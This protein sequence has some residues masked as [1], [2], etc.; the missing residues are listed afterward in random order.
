[1][2]PDLHVLIYFLNPSTPR[3]G[4]RMLFRANQRGQMGTCTQ[5][6]SVSSHFQSASRCSLPI[7]HIN[8]SRAL[9][10]AKLLIARE[11]IKWFLGTSIDAEQIFNRVKADK[12]QI[13]VQLL[14]QFANALPGTRRKCVSFNTIRI[15][16]LSE[17]QSTIPVNL[18]IYPFEKVDFSIRQSTV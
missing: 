10:T 3:F 17:S 14:A 7:A 8:Q 5:K 12:R 6:A 2:C 18:P 15:D 13:L 11:G 4:T 16:G 9:F 1:M